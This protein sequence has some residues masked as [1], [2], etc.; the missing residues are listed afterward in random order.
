MI[1]QLILHDMSNR[2]ELE[3][4]QRLLAT[5]VEQAGE[6]VIIVGI[7]GN[8]QYVNPACETVCG[9]SMTEMLGKNPRMLQSGKTPAYQYKLMWQEITSGNIWRGI[10]INRKKNGEI[11]HEEATITPIKDKDDKIL[12]YVAVKRDITHHLFLEYQI[13]Q[14]Q[15]IQAIGTLA[16]GV[17][18]DFNNILT[19][20][21]GYAELAQSQCDHDSPLHNNLVEIIRGADRASKLIDQ[22]LKFSRQGEKNVSDLWLGLIVKEAVRLLR[23]NLSPNIEL[24]YDFTDDF[25][26]KADPTQMHQIVMNLCTNA[27]QALEDQGGLIWLRLFRRAL[28]HHEGVRVGNLPPGSYVCLQIEDN[29]TGILPEYLQRIFEPYFTTKKLCEGTGLGLSVVHGIVNDHQGAVT[30]ESVV[31]QGSCF[32]VFLPEVT[33]EIDKNVSIESPP[34]SSPEEA[35][36]R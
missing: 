19:A 21:I 26:V 16:G 34:S 28:S 6:S 7:D 5:A 10:F 22:I 1:S 3:E 24:V 36:F 33:G 13:R 12:N 27:Y 35:V 14:S 8:I 32:T 18:H 4:G 29:G 17:A 23:V 20:I 30:V 25:L 9:Y 31:G 15:K 11:Y 2:F